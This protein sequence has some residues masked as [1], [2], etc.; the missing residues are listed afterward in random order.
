MDNEKLYTFDV[1]ITTQEDYEIHATSLEEAEQKL[2]EEVWKRVWN[3]GVIDWEFTLLLEE[4]N[5]D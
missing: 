5:D 4:S 1:I 2:R 3:P